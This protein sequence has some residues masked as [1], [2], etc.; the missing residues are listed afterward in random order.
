MLAL[1]CLRRLNDPGDT[2]ASAEI[3]SLGDCSEPEDWVIDRLAWLDPAGIRRAG[4]NRET[5][6]T[7]CS[8]V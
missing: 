2:I 8:S 4:V 3:I 1:A 7:P 6:H 5:T